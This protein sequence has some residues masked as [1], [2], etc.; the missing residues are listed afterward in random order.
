MKQNYTSAATSINK[1]KLPA[2]YSRVSIP[3]GSIVLDYGC[4]RYTDHIRKH[5][6]GSEYLPYDPFN[7]PQAVNHDSVMKINTA[8]IIGEPVTVICSNVL[9]VI[10]GESEIRDIL[11]NIAA[12]IRAT[13]GK[14]YITVYEG[15]RTGN[16]KQTGPDQYQRNECLSKYLK[17]VPDMVKARISR[18]MIILEV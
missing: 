4:G 15:D 12:I 13:G 2:I 10:D 3:A 14:A 8:R 5:L 17:F 11:R 16:G 7:Q 6:S 9:N 1:N 18:N